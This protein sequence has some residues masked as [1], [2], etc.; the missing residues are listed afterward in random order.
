M[1]LNTIGISE[2]KIRSALSGTMVGVC[3]NNV[4]K[5]NRRPGRGSQGTLEDNNLFGKSF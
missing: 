5:R 2:K 4:K 3:G 1:F